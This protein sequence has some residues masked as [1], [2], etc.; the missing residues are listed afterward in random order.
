MTSL[1]EL[2]NGLADRWSVV[3]LAMFVQSSLV[4]LVL[5]TPR[6]VTEPGS[7]G[8]PQVPAP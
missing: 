1:V 4:I 5:M 6:L 8:A 3:V 2:L 7:P